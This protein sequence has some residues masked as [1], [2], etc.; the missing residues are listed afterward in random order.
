MILSTNVLDKENEENS[1]D[2]DSIQK[3][4]IT[5]IENIL[6]SNPKRK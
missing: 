4:G 3:E 2:D 6:K 1:S 5:E